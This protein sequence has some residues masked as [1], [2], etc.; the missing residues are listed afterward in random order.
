MN[1][2]GSQHL[3]TRVI[4][5]QQGGIMINNNFNQIQISNNT[6]KEILYKI[7]FHSQRNLHIVICHKFGLSF[8]HQ[9]K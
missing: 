9:R 1:T 2:D 8:K 4:I 6:I 3:T 7:Y 5:N